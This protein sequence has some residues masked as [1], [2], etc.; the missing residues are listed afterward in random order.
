MLT[1]TKMNQIDFIM[2]L[3]WPGYVTIGMEQCPEAFPSLSMGGDY[4]ILRVSTVTM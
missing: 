3:I 4:I 1:A 2:L